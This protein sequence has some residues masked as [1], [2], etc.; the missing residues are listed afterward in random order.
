MA[1]ARRGE[2][3]VRAS[4]EAEVARELDEARVR[5]A[6]A[7]GLGRAVA[8]AVVD[9]D[10]LAGDA[11]RARGRRAPGG[12]EAAQRE[13]AGV[14]RHDH[15]REVDHARAP[16]PGSGRGGASGSSRGGASS[17]SR[18][19]ATIARAAVP[20]APRAAS[21]EDGTRSR[22]EGVAGQGS[23]STGSVGPRSCTT[24]VPTRAATWSGPVSGPIAS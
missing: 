6:L 1:P 22:R 8:R 12:C 2:A 3:A 4:G 13:L 21:P 5:M 17:S 14:P 7:H 18:A 11:R 24:G 15:D 23:F 16:A 20:P 10:E 9:D 19:D